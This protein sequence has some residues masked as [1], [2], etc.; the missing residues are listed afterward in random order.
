MWIQTAAFLNGEDPSGQKTSRFLLILSVPCCLSLL[1]STK[2]PYNRS[3][4]ERGSPQGSRGLQP[5]PPISTLLNDRRYRRAEIFFWSNEWLKALISKKSGKKNLHFFG[6]NMHLHLTFC[7]RRERTLV[8]TWKLI[9]CAS[10]L[11]KFVFIGVVFAYKTSQTLQNSLLAA[12]PAC[13]YS[14]LLASSG[15]SAF[16]VSP[17]AFLSSKI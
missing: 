7:K 14:C 10:C 11:A 15:G 12:D 6:A 5:S 4:F 9:H 17:Q 8:I 1:C 2:R 3:D 13:L 16:T